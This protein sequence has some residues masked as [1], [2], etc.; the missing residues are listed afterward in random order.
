[1]KQLFLL[2]DDNLIASELKSFLEREGYRVVWESTLKGARLAWPKHTFHLALVDINLPDGLG[3]DF[4]RG[5]KESGEAVPVIFLTA[6]LDEE[7]AVK[8]LNLGA[9]D[10]IRKPF[11]RKELLVRIRRYLNDRK[12][13]VEIGDLKLDP[14]KR[15]VS[16]RGK[17]IK[18]T[19][20]E[21]DLLMVLA[22]HPGQVVTRERVLAV[23]DEQG[24]VAERTINTYCSRLRKKL[25]EAGSEGFSISSVYGQGFRLDLELRKKAG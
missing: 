16:V 3:F 17:E 20:R 6:R 2:E 13:A 1:M 23:I 7:S 12:H 15:S 11:S 14:G 19:A 5:L 4:C 25:K 8:G 10:Y 18:L 9:A 24:E 21:F 22:E